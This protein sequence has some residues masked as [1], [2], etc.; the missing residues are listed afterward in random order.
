[1][2]LARSTTSLGKEQQPPADLALFKGS[3]SLAGLSESDTFE[4]S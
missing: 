4:Q 1:M 2:T 3:I